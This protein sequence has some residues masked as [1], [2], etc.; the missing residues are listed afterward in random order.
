MD[1]IWHTR[2][3]LNIS[4][5]TLEWFR[6]IE[7]KIKKNFFPHHYVHSWIDWQGNTCRQPKKKQNN[8]GDLKMWNGHRHKNEHHTILLSH[9]KR[10]NWWF[11]AAKSLNNEIET[12]HQ[13]FVNHLMMLKMGILESLFVK[14]SSWS[15]LCSSSQTLNRF[16][17]TKWIQNVVKWDSIPFR[18]KILKPENHFSFSTA[19]LCHPLFSCT[20]QEW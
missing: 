12:H 1:Y 5:R 9:C 2:R 19:S 16:L 15:R 20:K 4:F 3:T 8:L 18:A 14:S 7:R 13:T 10:L 17:Y 11:W 6:T